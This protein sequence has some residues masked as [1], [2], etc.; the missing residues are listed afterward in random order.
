MLE[1][2]LTFEGGYAS[3]RFPVKSVAV[4]TLEYGT[5]TFVHCEKNAEWILQ[6]SCGVSEKATLKRS[7]LFAELRKKL[8]AANA[9]HA[10]A[11]E[12]AVADQDAAAVDEDDPMSALRA[13][14][15][16]SKTAKAKKRKYTS[17]RGKNCPR[18]VTMPARE[19]NK[20]PH[21]ERTQ[22]VLLLPMSTNAL[23]I[24]S[25][26]VPWLLTYLADECGPGGSQGVRMF[27]AED[28]DEDE[29]NARVCT[30]DGL[31]LKW[32]STA[33]TLTGTALS[34]PLEGKVWQ[35]NM[36]NFT[37]DKWD[38]VGATRG[39]GVSFTGATPLQK[40]NAAW[41]YVEQLCAQ[42]LRQ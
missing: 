27:D 17:R 18:M 16:P 24:R 23:Y 5:V 37:A 36:A 33:E 3:Q 12:A 34:G 21:S 20:F 26:D 15:V 9:E 11:D 42:Q 22:N 6:A 31:D 2:Q 25:D 38:A 30:V 10:R 14:A 7:T 29:D 32:D 13:V 40:R 28:E 8:V 19:P 39:Y 1:T 35:M 41:E 4:E